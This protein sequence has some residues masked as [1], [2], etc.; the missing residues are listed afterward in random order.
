MIDVW[1]DRTYMRRVCEFTKY[2]IRKGTKIYLRWIFGGS[3]ALYRNTRTSA[4]D[5][6]NETPSQISPFDLFS[7][8]RGNTKGVK[9]LFWGHNTNFVTVIEP[10]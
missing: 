9:G 6:T 5:K 4:P 7:E 3:W 10:S 2:S 1:R 8:N